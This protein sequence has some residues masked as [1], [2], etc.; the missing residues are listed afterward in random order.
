MVRSVFQDESSKPYSLRDLYGTYRVKAADCYTLWGGGLPQRC[1]IN[2]L[3]ITA[4]ILHLLAC[5]IYNYSLFKVNIITIS[6]TAV[7]SL[8]NKGRHTL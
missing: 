6:I 1:C 5:L 3:P 7:L 4:H 8:L 2:Y